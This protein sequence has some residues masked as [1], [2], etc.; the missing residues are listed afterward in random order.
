MKHIHSWKLFCIIFYQNFSNQLF[1]SFGLVWP[2]QQFFNYL[3]SLDYFHVR[4]KIL[5]ICWIGLFT[6]HISFSIYDDLWGPP[7]NIG[8][9]ILRPVYKSYFKSTQGINMYLNTK[10]CK[11]TKAAIRYVLLKNMP[12]LDPETIRKYLH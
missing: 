10:C 4:I 3:L 8:Q 6:S 9:Y 12:Y 7:W 11:G 2:K 5:D 1:L